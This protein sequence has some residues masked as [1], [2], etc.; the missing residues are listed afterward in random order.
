MN[1]SI[2]P[3]YD[4]TIYEASA[5]MNTGIDQLLE[6]EK[7]VDLSNEYNSRILIK[8]DLSTVSS[9]IASGDITSP[10]FYLTM[11]CIDA[12]EIPAEY[13]L[14]AYYVSESWDNG[15]GRF[16]N[17]PSTKEG[18]S[19][20]WRDGETPASP[21]QTSSYTTGTTGSWA[22]TEGGGT[23]YTASVASQS[24]SFQ[25]ADIR[26]DVTTMV[27]EWI[28]GSISNNGF[29]I[30]RSD[31][32]EQS[33]TELG[34]ISFYSKETNTI[35][36]PRIEILY[37]DSSWSTGSLT[38]LTDDNINVYL[39]GLRAEYNENEI[40]K[41]RIY[42]RPTF[43]ARTYST[44]S[45][46]MQVKYLPTSSYYELRDA[47]TEEVI[48]PFDTNYTKISCDSTSN[49]YRFRMDGL[50]PERFYKFVYKVVRD[51]GDRVEYFDNDYIFKTVR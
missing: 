27:N 21:W 30:K 41:I 20:E 32:D 1:Y 49:F 23:W 11:Y 51:G 8:F 2:Y 18:V 40:A 47:L 25:S 44:S 39:K 34:K 17:D 29:I 7:S 45:A 31:S 12:K 3:L 4:A 28:S 42:G 48:V 22:T 26:M 37:D 50:M 24:Y 6:I 43:P 35:Y 38:E 19:W 9:S 5:S 16:Y 46:Y 13:T 33:R 10:K 36:V 15:L 14:Y